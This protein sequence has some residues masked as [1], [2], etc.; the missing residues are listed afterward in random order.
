MCAFPFPSTII[1]THTHTQ[2]VEAK[3]T[4]PEIEN[5]LSVSYK[6]NPRPPNAFWVHGKHSQNSFPWPPFEPLSWFRGSGTYHGSG[7]QWRKNKQTTTCSSQTG[8]VG[9]HRKYQPKKDT[10]K[11]QQKK[12]TTS[13]D[14]CLAAL[15]GEGL[16]SFFRSTCIHKQTKISQNVHFHSRASINSP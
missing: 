10:T 16:A 14:E 12:T 3:S 4:F 13:A 2:A 15:H 11:R 6:Q 8:R 5:H 1:Q 7:A 9:R